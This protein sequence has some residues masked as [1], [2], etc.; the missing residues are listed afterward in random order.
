MVCSGNS[1]YPCVYR[2]LLTIGSLSYCNVGL[3]LCI[4]GTPADQAKDDVAERFIPVYTGNSYAGV[5]YDNGG[6]VY[7]CVYR[8]LNVLNVFYSFLH[9]L[10][11]CI[12]GTL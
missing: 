1:V 6:A 2:E 8:E 11:L 12:Q 7:P 4:Q 5:Y 3:S 10:S 9:G